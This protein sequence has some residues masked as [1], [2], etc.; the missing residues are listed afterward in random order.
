MQ[1][2]LFHAY[3]VDEHTI[4][5]LQKIDSFTLEE[6][7]RDH[8]LCV[9]V[10]PKLLQPELLRLA[11]I[12]HDIAKGRSGD[13]SDLGSDFVYDFALLHDFSV[14]E[15]ELASWLVKTTY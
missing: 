7:R 12:F 13:H 15:A 6:N 2:D 3:T 4:R 1:F 14:K 5:V 11:A 8:P 10:Y 9:S